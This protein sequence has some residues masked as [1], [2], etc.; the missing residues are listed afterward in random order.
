MTQI[1]VPVAQVLQWHNERLQ[2]GSTLMGL[3]NQNRIEAFYNKNS[4]RI[5]SILGKNE[6][7]LREFYQFDGGNVLRNG[8][9]PVLLEG[10]TEEGFKDAM[11]KFQTEIVAINI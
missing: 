10:K 3:L 6:K 7:I 11:T 9:T 2:L 1:N 5:Q 8:D 4:V